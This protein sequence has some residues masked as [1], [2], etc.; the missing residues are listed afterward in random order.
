MYFVITMQDKGMSPRCVGYFETFQEAENIILN[1]VCDIFEY[2]YDYVIIENIKPGLYQ[3][4]QKPSWYKWNDTND[5]YE[6][7]N[8]P[9][10]ANGFYGWGIG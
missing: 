4:D 7:I 8:K 6:L 1:N 3:Y 9:E 2:Y 5:C 10:F